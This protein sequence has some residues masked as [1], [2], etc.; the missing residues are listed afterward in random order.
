MKKPSPQKTTKKKTLTV[1][2]AKPKIH[3]V[4]EYLDDE[5]KPIASKLD[6]LG[7]HTLAD[8]LERQAHQLRQ[9]EQPEVLTVSTTVLDLR[10]QMKK[11]LCAFAEFYGADKMQESEKL[12]TGARWFLESS[13]PMIEAV[14]RNTDR[15]T[16]YRDAEGLNDSAY[17]EDLIRNALQTWTSHITPQLPKEED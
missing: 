13:L 8:K 5:L 14:S 6:I 4:P 9:M 10:P 2:T 15:Q 7:R 12:A 1:P 11:A 17:T 3:P 16:A